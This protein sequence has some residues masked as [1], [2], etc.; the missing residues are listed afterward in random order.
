MTHDGVVYF[1]EEL[2]PQGLR[3]DQESLAGSISNREGMPSGRVAP[4]LQKTKQ[5]NLK[6]KFKNSKFKKALYLSQFKRQIEGHKSFGTPNLGFMTHR[7]IVRSHTGGEIH[8]PN[9]LMQNLPGPHDKLGDRKSE[10][11]A[12]ITTSRYR[13]DQAQ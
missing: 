3:T 7:N 8:D 9:G 13:Y 10:V 12:G 1:P 5:L 4:F 6:L 2:M 11:V